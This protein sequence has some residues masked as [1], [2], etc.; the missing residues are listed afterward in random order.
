MG[1]FESIQSFP[2]TLLDLTPVARDVMQH[3]ERQGYEVQGEQTITR[4]WD[5]S[6]HKGGFFKT[7][8]GMKTALKIALESVGGMTTAK[9]GIGIFGLQAIPS[10]IS[11][12]FFWPVLIP[13]IWGMVQQAKLDEEALRCIET[14]LQAHASTLSRPASDTA[15]PAAQGT[16]CT[17]CGTRLS[18]TAK[19]C[20]ECGTKMT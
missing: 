14:S 15:T 3:F 2:T 12:L 20:S 11:L 18:E 16:F 4:G 13:Q 9:A 8:V 17:N 19:F 6:V 10:A 5:I 7:V 1:V